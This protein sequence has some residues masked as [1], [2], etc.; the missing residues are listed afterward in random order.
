MSVLGQLRYLEFADMLIGRCVLLTCTQQFTSI[1]SHVYTISIFLGP[2]I[3]IAHSF[4]FCGLSYYL[5][6]IIEK[7]YVRNIVVIAIMIVIVCG[8]FLIG[9]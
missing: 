2:T 9:H 7:R 6:I 3:S 5:F 4:A 8:V 1:I